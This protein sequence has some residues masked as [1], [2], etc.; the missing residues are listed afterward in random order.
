MCACVCV[1]ARAERAVALL[2]FSEPGSSPLGDLLGLAQRHKTASELNS[3]IL[4]SQVSEGERNG[5]TELAFAHTAVP[6]KRDEVKRQ[7]FQ[8]RGCTTHGGEGM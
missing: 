1:C 6:A 3:A 2:A 4:Q 7:T 8:R 5:T